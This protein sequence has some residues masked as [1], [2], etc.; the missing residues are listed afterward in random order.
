MFSQV[1]VCPQ[2][3]GGVH[4]LPGR[5]LPPE[6]ATSV[7][8]THP[9]GMHSCSEFFCG[10]I[11]VYNKERCTPIIPNQRMLSN[12]HAEYLNHNSALYCMRRKEAL[13]DFID[14]PEKPSFID[15]KCVAVT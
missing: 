2:G 12:Q 8:G 7:E 15:R 11:V 14:L 9:T 1:S 6:M 10:I 3:G 5:H 4:P 13:K